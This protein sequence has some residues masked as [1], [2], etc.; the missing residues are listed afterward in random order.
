M[1]KT[2]LHE[3]TFRVIGPLRVDSPVDYRRKWLEM[4]TT[5]VPFDDSLARFWTNI[6]ATG[7]LTRHGVT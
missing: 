1:M 3:N 6:E 7:D 4:H 5:G 2:L